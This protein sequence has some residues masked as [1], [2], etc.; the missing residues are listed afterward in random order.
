MPE[1]TADS[2]AGSLFAIRAGV[3]FA[4]DTAPAGRLIDKRGAP[5]AWSGRCE[6]VDAR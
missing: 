6:S 3:C 4:G 5:G 1:W 2:P